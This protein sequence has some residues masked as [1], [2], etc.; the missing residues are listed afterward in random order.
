MS[1]LLH[2]VGD[3]SLFG[4]EFFW[5]EDDLFKN[6]Q[7]FS[8]WKKNSSVL[9]EEGTSWPGSELI[10][11]YVAIG[12]SESV[13]AQSDSDVDLVKGQRLMSA[14]KLP[15]KRKQTSSLA[16]AQAPANYARE[17]QRGKNWEKT[18]EDILV[19]LR[20]KD[21][22]WRSISEYLK[23][24][25]FIRDHRHCS[26]KWYALRKHYLEIQQWTM[27]NPNINYWDLADSER[28][29]TVPSSFCQ[30][31]Y[32]IFGAA[33][34]KPEVRKRPQQNLNPRRRPDPSPSRFGPA[35]GGLAL[36]SS[37]SSDQAFTPQPSCQPSVPQ[38]VLQQHAGDRFTSGDAAYESER[39]EAGDFLPNQAT[40]EYSNQPYLDIGV[41][42]AEIRELSHTLKQKFAAEEEERMRNMKIKETKLQLKLDRFQYK[43]QRDEEMRNRRGL[44]L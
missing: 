32:Q 34:Q 26:D 4:P 8:P 31:W 30:R 41:L 5:S 10:E 20:G 18:E 15:M 37:P 17:R 39:R 6:Q 13:E 23:S 9:P 24:S 42:W 11:D 14:N 25:G 21:M 7:F 27:K 44:M 12:I 3:V 43:R 16:E 33:C 29:R 38:E 2:P 35:V 22:D 1:D 36:D 40:V 28:I 19:E